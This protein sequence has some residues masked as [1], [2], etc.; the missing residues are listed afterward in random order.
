MCGKF[1]GY[2]LVVWGSTFGRV[3]IGPG[4]LGASYTL[5]TELLFFENKVGRSVKLTNLHHIMKQQKLRICR[6]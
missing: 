2:E 5:G 6:V 4:S 1:I 3:R